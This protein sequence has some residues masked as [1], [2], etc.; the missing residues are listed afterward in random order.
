MKSIE[1]PQQCFLETRFI[2]IFMYRYDN[3]QV[4]VKIVTNDTQLDFNQKQH[5]IATL[6]INKHQRNL[7]FHENTTWINHVNHHCCIQRM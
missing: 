3:L 5:K 1:Q 6:S 2:T 4:A 7:I